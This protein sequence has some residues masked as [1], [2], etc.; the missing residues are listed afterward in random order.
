VFLS[1]AA[2]F[3]PGFADFGIGHTSQDL[4]FLT[5]ISYIEASVLRTALL[6]EAIAVL[7]EILVLLPEKAQLLLPSLPL[8]LDDL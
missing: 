5:H 4:S 6:F 1:F 2:L 7:A 8:L 3:L